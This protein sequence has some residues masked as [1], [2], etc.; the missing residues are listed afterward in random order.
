MPQNAEIVN[1]V[2]LFSMFSILREGGRSRVAR[3]AFERHR[4]GG[5]EF[6]PFRGSAALGF[7]GERKPGMARASRGRTPDRRVKL[8]SRQPVCSYS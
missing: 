8:V 1:I 4:P 7:E 6:R 3:C 2:L 5:V